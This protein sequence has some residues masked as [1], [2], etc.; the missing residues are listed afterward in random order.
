MAYIFDSK[1][2]HSEFSEQEKKDVYN[3]V[4]QKY[5]CNSMMS[6]MLKSNAKSSPFEVKF[7]DESIVKEVTTYEW[8]KS[9]QIQ[10]N[11]FNNKVFSEVEQLI[12]AT[13]SSKSVERI[14]STFG[15]IQSKV[16]KSFKI[17]VFI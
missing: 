7:F 6:I 11:N 8:W 13:A 3:F 4:K 15:L 2:N 14:F 10:I 16:G 1:Y 12:R 9:Q 17:G 5:P